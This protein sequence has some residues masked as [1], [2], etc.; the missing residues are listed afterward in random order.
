[1]IKINF[2]DLIKSYTP[3]AMLF[4]V[5]FSYIFVL[6]LYELWRY[7]GVSHMK[8]L[9]ADLHAVLSAIECHSRGTNVFQTNPCDVAGRVHVYGSLWLHLGALGM[10]S[11]H[12]FSKGFVVDVVFMAIAV[13][14]IKPACKADFAKSCLILFSPAVTL[15][16]ERANNDLI[17]FSLLAGA[18]LL[19]AQRPRVAQVSGLLIIY[20]S[21]L[22]KFYPS[23]L[24]AATLFTARRNL[25]ELVFIAAAAMGLSALWLVT[26]F[27]ELMLVKDL[28]PKPLDF[29]ATGARALFVYVGRPYPWILTIPIGWWLLGFVVL[30]AVGSVGLAYRLKVN[31]ALGSS[32]IDRSMFNYV[33]FIFGLAILFITYTINTNYDYRW[34][35]FIFTMPLL[36]DIQKAAATHRSASRLATVALLCAFITMWTEAV[37]ANG[38][39][40]VF[41]INIFFNIGR[42]TF[43]IEL[44]QQFL[45][46]LSAWGLFMILFALAINQFPQKEERHSL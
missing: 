6:A 36:F 45:K 17:V 22:L 28:V 29:Y 27:N 3:A 5:W 42:S 40:G 19:I 30:I 31:Q 1:M 13:L 26:N 8:P 38:V 35:F 21:A 7:V 43:S 9:F 10:G 16:V 12:L 4:S 15:G 46:E 18:A 14:L 39:F 2:K 20:L 34:V 41:N 25:K 24:F 44:L 11:V 23:V 37:R 33:I 32:S